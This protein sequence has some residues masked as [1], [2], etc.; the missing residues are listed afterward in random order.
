M[1]ILNVYT[2]HNTMPAEFSPLSITCAKLISASFDK[3]IASGKIL[4]FIVINT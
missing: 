2:V 4:N 3:A 1:M